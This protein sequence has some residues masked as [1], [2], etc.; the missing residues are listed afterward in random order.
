MPNTLARA[1][2]PLLMVLAFAGCTIDTGATGSS[3]SSATSQPLVAAVQINS[4]GEALGAFGAD[5]YF[6]GGTAYVG[7]AAVTTEGVANAAPLS[8][9]QSERYGNFSYTIGSLTAGANYVVRLHFAEVYFTAANSRVFNTSINGAQVLSNFDIVAVA[10]Q[11][12]KAIV[13]DF[14]AAASSQGEIVI[15]F[16]SI[17]DYAKVS[18][19]EILSDSSGS[20]PAGSNEGSASR[21]TTTAVSG[22]TT[23]AQINSGGTAAGAF[24]ADEGFVGGTAYSA[25]AD[26]ITAG[27]ANAA[28]LSVYQSERYG[29]F[30]Y[31][32]GGLT[33]GGN[34]TVRLHFAEIW[35]TAANSRVFNTF[36]NGV[37]VLSNFDIVV[38]AGQANKAIALDFNTVANSQGQIVIAYSTIKDNAK[39]SGIEIFPSTGSSP[40]PSPPPANRSPT[41]ASSAAASPKPAHAFG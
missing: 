20:V 15:D 10:G 19:I 28:P 24:S 30:S 41:V 11:A 32:V 37:Q 25:A 34:Y 35:F 8:V 12:N 26:V 40:P 21:D 2:A 31:T 38:A 13:L 7:T 4:G 5:Q 22:T 9:Y 33:V 36:I 39:S 3:S 14:S 16:T 23:L 29:D 1:L 17:K 18:G 6:S 27:V